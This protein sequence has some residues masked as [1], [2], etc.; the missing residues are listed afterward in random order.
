MFQLPQL[1]YAYNALDPYIDEETMKVHHD[2][3]HLAYINKLNEALQK[4]PDLEDKS[5]LGL[6]KNLELVPEEIRQ[7]VRNN[8]GGHYNHSLFWQNLKPTQGRLREAVR[9][10]MPGD[11]EEPEDHL[12]IIAEIENRWD[13]FEKFKTEF[14]KVSDEFFGSGWCW[15]VLDKDG[16]LQITALSNHDCPLSVGQIPIIVLDLWEH[17]YYL[18]YQNRRPEYVANWWHLVNWEEAEKRFLAAKLPGE[19]EPQ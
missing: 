14:S 11:K 8:G 10:L 3:H 19:R 16:Q 4:Y 15:L 2:G 1:P 7:K 12:Q 13:S 5:V 18:K 9:G 17:A 6:L